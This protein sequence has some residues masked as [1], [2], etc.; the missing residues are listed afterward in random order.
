LH[1]DIK[2]EGVLM[3]KAFSANSFH[4]WFENGMRVDLPKVVAKEKEKTEVREAVIKLG[5]NVF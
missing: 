4:E 1:N 3:N 5:D 2:P